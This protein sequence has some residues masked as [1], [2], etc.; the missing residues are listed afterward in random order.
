MEPLLRRMWRAATVGATTIVARPTIEL[1]E[2]GF[3]C[4][5]HIVCI[6]RVRFDRSVQALESRASIVARLCMH[7]VVWLHMHVVVWLHMHVV[8]LLYIYVVVRLSMHAA[9]WFY[10]HIIAML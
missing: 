8:V 4:S 1:Q 7:V 3:Q 6:A 10:M 2:E 5:T 9:V